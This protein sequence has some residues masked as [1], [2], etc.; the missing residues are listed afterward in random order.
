MSNTENIEEE[1]TNEEVGNELIE[2]TNSILENIN[3]NFRRRAR[4]RLLSNDLDIRNRISRNT[5][6]LDNFLRSRV[7][8]RE[9][10]EATRCNYL[11]NPERFCSRMKTNN[12]DYCIY[13][14]S[15]LSNTRLSS[16]RL[17][18]RPRGRPRRNIYSIEDIR[19]S[20]ESQRVISPVFIGVSSSNISLGVTSSNSNIDDNVSIGITND[21]NIS[22]GVTND[23][24]IVRHWVQNNDNNNVSLGISTTNSNDVPELNLF[25]LIT[26]H[27]RRNGRTFDFLN[28]EFSIPRDNL[29]ELKEQ[30]DKNGKCPLCQKTVYSPFV[31]LDCNHKFHLNCFIILNTDEDNKYELME[32]CLKCGEKINMNLKEE[33]DC[34]IC[35]EKLIDDDIEIELPCKHRFH[36]YCIQRWVDINKN[37][38][39][40][41]KTF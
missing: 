2:Q 1:K 30:K 17:L 8:L 12:S 35:L 39:L 3:H 21:N 5:N 36:V 33:N 7:N 40:C 9:Q 31:M 10:L 19:N 20:I 25:N 22:I 27:G 14:Q 29:A 24:N 32:E 6:N 18:E 34:S 16:Q 41:R 13:H 11:T 4:E 37:C 38:P 28:R 26:R 15:I 23:N